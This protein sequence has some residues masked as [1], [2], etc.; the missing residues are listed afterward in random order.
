MRTCV[1]LLGI[2]LLLVSSFASH[3]ATAR[4]IEEAVAAE[5]WGR[6]ARI[7]DT[8]KKAGV[9]TDA[10]LMIAAAQAGRTGVI[11]K[12]VAAGVPADIAR[13]TGA[14][15]GENALMHAASRGRI[16]T[17]KWLLAHGAKATY[18]GRCD[19][20]ACTGHTAL[21]GVA[22]GGSVE[23]TKLLLDAG[24]D[25]NA[26]GGRCT[27]LANFSAN[28]GVY[29]L[30]VAH[31]GRDDFPHPFTTQK[32]KP[33][34]ATAPPEVAAPT[35]QALGVAE[36]LPTAAPA[37]PVPSGR[38]RLAIVADEANEAAAIALTAR[39]GSAPGIELVERQEIDRILAEQRL[40]RGLAANAAS[41][42]QLGAWLHA[43]AFVFIRE[44]DLLGTKTVESRLVRVS[45]G[46]VIETLH[47][48]APIA[49]ATAW[50]DALA[51]HASALAMR[52]TQ[53][54]A[55][56]V[57]LLGVRST[58]GSKNALELERTLGVL[59]RHRLGRDPRLVL[60]ERSAL[61][62]LAAEAGGDANTFWHGR[63]L[64][65]GAVEP[66]LAKPGA[67]RFSV[68]LQ[69]AGGGEV[70][71]GSGAGD[72][73]H[74]GAAVDA[75]LQAALAKLRPGDARVSGDDLAEA[76]RFADEA[77][78]AS[79]IQ[80]Y[81]PAMEAADAAWALG[82]RT[83]EVARLR[84]D[85]A[86]RFLRMQRRT[87]TGDFPL[88]EDWS[89]H[90][91]FHHPQRRADCP[92]GAEWLVITTR[93]LD[94]WRAELSRI[95]T[96]DDA[97]RIA[98]LE[99]GLAVLDQV[100]FAAAAFDTA[101]E[102]ARQRDR[103]AAMR[104]T[105]RAAS[106]EAMTAAGRLPDAKAEIA[107]AV[108]N[109]ACAVAMHETSEHAGAAI[110][111][112]L[113]R[114][115]RTD[116]A[117]GR[118]AV[119]AKLW[120]EPNDA[121]A[122]AVGTRITS[123]LLASKAP[124]D[125]LFGNRLAST[126]QSLVATRAAAQRGAIA[127]FRELLPAWAADMRLQEIGV[128][129]LQGMELFRRE[130]DPD[131]PMVKMAINS[132]PQTFAFSP[133][134]RA[135]RVEVMLAIFGQADP[136]TALS[137]WWSPESYLPEEIERL[138]RA[139]GEWADRNANRELSVTEQSRKMNWLG[140]AGAIAKPAP[141]APLR[142][143]RYWRASDFAEPRG[144]DVTIDLN[145]ALFADGALWILGERT[146]NSAREQNVERFIY[147]VRFPTLETEVIAMPSTQRRI[148]IGEGH[149][150][151]GSLFPMADAVYV[152]LSDEC[153][154]TYDRRAGSWKINREFKPA[155]ALRPVWHD[156]FIYFVQR[157]EGSDALLRWDCSTGAID[158]LAS[159]RRKP[160]QTPLDNAALFYRA[161]RISNGQLLVDTATRREGQKE[162]GS[163][164]PRQPLTGTK[165]TAWAAASKDLHGP[166][167]TFD[168]PTKQWNPKPAQDDGREPRT[169]PPL[170]APKLPP[171]SALPAL[172]ARGAFHPP[173]D[174][175]HLVI[176]TGMGPE[177]QVELVPAQAPSGSAAAMSAVGPL[178]S[179]PAP[180]GLIVSGM[181]FRIGFWFVPHSDLR[182]SLPRR[183]SAPNATPPASPRSP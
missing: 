146:E 169:R 134:Y 77:R 95:E 69:P 98:W 63:Y 34:T 160:E 78:V 110:D 24:A 140:L 133:E 12:L 11:E 123:T 151:G 8:A 152:L 59:L 136:A 19:D 157:D 67:F 13:T 76:Q 104:E 103:L 26:G 5:E 35:L 137:L 97:A 55:L 22:T 164:I 33:T 25:P 143:T 106:A 36:L 86:L 115:F 162:P 61:D 145:G 30:L 58:L 80:L 138:N 148:R 3:A 18:V 38:C 91:L 45:P 119:R 43:D 71:A 96:Q 159:T 102:I 28:T 10:A 135:F 56:A 39:L 101:A 165:S 153:V 89:S 126:R 182:N 9:S 44:R 179:W 99:F 27:H 154:G 2:T 16:E 142:V 32:A 74:P 68:R 6:I 17:V 166:V 172:T 48:P 139:I 125:R 50:A 112:L 114:H 72:R 1:S 79:L 41:A 60:L 183:T 177:I 150:T 87:V 171:F 51:P 141:T 167:V 49:N 158:L 64:V 53:R 129:T 20:G 168:P 121:R 90:D 75:A 14:S 113:A 85:A 163:G 83:P 127:A 21:N 40:A 93:A 147:R 94:S 111:S 4:E 15:R 130:L 155:G 81:A 170:I 31:G 180:G 108:Q 62:T 175:S 161:L 92:D 124:E 118:A 122:A 23:I 131:L 66:D 144:F 120:F 46:V 70:I 178:T 173:F 73:E 82:L 37:A 65:E 42:G 128:H 52:A 176:A 105:W 181:A 174:G 88:S 57:S 107:F 29:E 109:V 132:S 100:K 84:I 7:R 156:G 117:Y 47:H 149:R 116:D 54:D